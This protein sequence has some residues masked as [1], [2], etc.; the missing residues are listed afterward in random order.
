M[1]KRFFS[2]GLMII[3]AIGAWADVTPT[4]REATNELFRLERQ[5]ANSDYF[6]SGGSLT[7]NN[8]QNKPSNAPDNCWYLAKNNSTTSYI[9]ITLPSGFSL[10]SGDVVDIYGY[11]PLSYNSSRGF[12]LHIETPT[13]DNSKAL[14][15]MPSSGY[16]GYA[17]A[18]AR[19]T[20]TAEDGISGSTTLYIRGDG[21]NAV[22]IQKVSISRS[23]ADDMVP[24]AVSNKTW[25]LYSMA[26]TNDRSGSAYSSSA[27]NDDLFYAKGVIEYKQSTT[28]LR[29]G[30]R[31]T[32]TESNEFDFA[33]QNALGFV[34]ESGT[35]YITVYYAGSAPIVKA[36]TGSASS[37]LSGTEGNADTYYGTPVHYTFTRDSYDTPIFITKGSNNPTITKIIVSSSEYVTA[38]TISQSDNTVTITAGSSNKGNNV[39]TYYTTDG[40]NPTSNSSVYSEAITLTQSCTIKAI[41]ISSESVSSEVASKSC[42]YTSTATALTSENVSVA[43]VTYNGSEQ[44]AVVKYNTT[45]LTKGT[46]YTVTGTDALTNAGSTTFTI[47]GTGNYT[48][49]VSDLTFTITP[50]EVMVTS[51]ITANNKVYD[52]NTTATLV[53]TGATIDGKVGEDELTVSSATGSFSDANVGENKEVTINN[54]TFGGEKAGNYTLSAT[55]NQ[56]TTPATISQ[57][58]NSLSGSIAIEGWTYGATANTPSGVTATFGEVAYKYSIAADGTYG[59]YDAIVNGA[60]GTWWVKAYVDGTENYTAVESDA[61][62]FTIS[63]AQQTAIITAEAT[64]STTYNGQAQP[65]T[66]T[67]DHGALLITYYTNE[68]HTEGATTEAPINAGTYYAIVSQSDANY[69]SDPVNATY[70]IN[71]ATLTATANNQSKTVGEDNPELTVTV[72]GFV[73]EETAEALT[74]AGAYTAPTATCAATTE[75]AAGAY[76]ILPANGAATNYTFNYVKGTLTVNAPTSIYDLYDFATWANENI[77]NADV[78]AVIIDGNLVASEKTMTLNGAISITGGFKVRTNNATTTGIHRAK[79]TGTL[80]INSLKAG[81]WFM[82]ECTS[83]TGTGAVLTFNNNNAYPLDEANLDVNGQVLVSGTIYVVKEDGDLPFVFGDANAQSY[84]HK[85]EI[86]NTDKLPAPVINFDATNK[87]VTITAYNSTKDNTVPTIYFAKNDEDLAVYDGNPISI[88]EPI[89]IKA[90]SVIS[91]SYKSTLVSKAVSGYTISAPSISASE[92]GLVTITPGERSDENEAITTYYT[93]DNSDP[94]TNENKLTYTAPFTP[95]KTAIIRAYS[96]Y[97]NYTTVISDEA[98]PLKVRIGTF[99]PEANVYDF[100][101]ADGDFQEI[102]YASTPETLSYIYNSNNTTASF[103]EISANYLPTATSSAKIMWRDKSGELANGGL[104]AIDGKARYIGITGLTVGQRL[105]IEFNGGSISYVTGTGEGAGKIALGNTDLIA[106][107]S[108]ITSTSTYTVSTAG[109]I[110]IQCGTATVIKNISVLGAVQSYALNVSYDSTKGSVTDDSG[111]ELAESYPEGSTVSL[112]ATATAEGYQFS[113]WMD[114]DDNFLSLK[115]P[116]EVTINSATT[117][118]AVFNQPTSPAPAILSEKSWKF[119]DFTVGTILSGTK[120]Y[121]Y[122]GLYINGHYSDESNQAQILTI[123]PAVNTTIAGELSQRLRIAGKNNSIK[124]TTNVSDFNSDAIAFMAGKPGVVTADVKGSSGNKYNIYIAGELSQVDMTGTLQL[125]QKDITVASSV[126]ISSNNGGHD[127]YAVKFTPETVTAP[128]ISS[129][130]SVGT[131]T[132]GTSN[133]TDE[134]NKAIKTY[135]TIDGTDPTTESTLYDGVIMASGSDITVKAISINTITGTISEITTETGLTLALPAKTVAITAATGGSVTWKVSGTTENTDQ[136]NFSQ[137]T[138]IEVTATPASGYMFQNWTVGEEIVAKTPVYTFTLNNDVTLVAN[139]K[140]MGN[141]VPVILTAGQS[142]TDGRIDATELPETYTGLTNCLWSYANAQ[143]SPAG[144]FNNKVFEIGDFTAYTPT[145]DTGTQWAYDAVVYD[146]I[147]KQLGSNFYVIKQSKGNTGISPAS[148]GCGLFWSANPL[149][150]SRTTSANEG[151]LSLLKALCDHIDASLEKLP[152]GKTADIKFLM[153]HQGEGDGNGSQGPVYYSQ[154]KAVINH[155]RNHLAAKNAKYSNLPFILGGISSS[156]AQ[157]R[158]EVE[159]AKQQLAAED[160]NIYYVSADEVDETGLKS[161]VLHFNA[162]G[163]QSFGNKVWQTIYE[164]NLLLGLEDGTGNSEP[165]ADILE[166]SEPITSTTKWDFSDIDAG[167]AYAEKTDVNGLYLHGSSSNNMTV[168]ATDVTSVTYYDGD[169]VTTS[170]ALRSASGD[171]SK[172]MTNGLTA[173]DVVAVDRMIGVNT[174]AAG[175]FYAVIAPETQPTTDQSARELYLLFNGEKVATINALE[176]WNACDDHTVKLQYTTDKAGTFFLTGQHPYLLYAAKFVKAGE[177]IGGFSI[178]TVAEGGTITLTAPEGKTLNS[179]FDKGEEVTLKATPDDGY[180]FMKWTDENDQKLGSSETLTITM[181]SNVT[182]KA[183]FISS[184]DKPTISK[185]YTVNEDS[186]TYTINYMEGSTLHYTLPGGTE[187]TA[188]DGESVQVNVTKIGDMTAYAMYGELSSETVSQRVYGP[189]PKIESDG[190]YDFSK[191]KEYMAKDYTL[192]SIG[193]GDAVTVGNV[194]LHK[195]DAV[196][197]KTLDRFAFAPKLNSNGK[198]AA[199]WMLL[200]AGRLRA[201]KSVM[202]DTLAILNLETGTYVKITYSGG[203]ALRYMK[204]SSAKLTE[205]TDTLTSDKLYE[206]L[207]DGALL[208]TTPANENSHCDITAISI[209][210]VETVSTPTLALKNDITT[211]VVR[212]RQGASSFGKSVITYYTTDGS[213]PTAENGTAVTKSP[214]DIKLETTST[215]KAIT[216]SEAGTASNVASA[217][218]IVKDESETEA[219]AELATINDDNTATVTGVAISEE[220]TTVTISASVGDAPVTAIAD[221]IF[222]ANNTENVAAI[223]LSETAVTLEG[224]REEILALKNINEA[225][226][227]Y[228]PTTANVTGTNIITKSGTGNEA[229]YKCVDYQLYDGKQSIVPHDFTAET[230]TLNREFTAD[231]RCTVCLPYAFTAT[232]GTYYKFTGINNGKVQMTAQEDGTKLDANTPYIF[233][234]NSGTDAISATDVEVSISDTPQTENAD[235]QFAFIGTYEQIEWDSPE[236]IYGFAAE[237]INGTEIGQFVRVE[238]GA[239][240]DAYRAYLKYTGDTKINDVSATRGMG[241]NIPKKLEIEWLPASTNKNTTT[242]ENVEVPATEDSPVYN[243]NGQRVDDSYKGLIIRNGKVII[244]K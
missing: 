57:A 133:L 13:S 46:D 179:T 194:T 86:R 67:V 28:P 50:K 49:T 111:N 77:N 17:L 128:I 78:D 122:D 172:F 131:I 206:V 96:V 242:I 43:S 143:I 8:I 89:T 218:F 192:G 16:T 209:A 47:E 112:K 117:I 1:T 214:Y 40:S 231:K 26:Q 241:N 53:L 31:M 243:L 94:K 105:I 29:W 19:Y 204:E 62:S 129:N 106:G 150:M 157:Y 197:G 176:A 10:R 95:E 221:N 222:T 60:V 79:G 121:E 98:T 159:T 81:D 59:T 230:A 107:S 130:E 83:S 30:V 153:W 4:T 63:A 220:T 114:A 24:N 34:L 169:V 124:A 126:F 213:V 48:G 102:T 154:L 205:E 76:D 225:T 211:N 156:S 163:A 54:I 125:L 187:Q 165:V 185:T 190:L 75:S 65:L 234:P 45:T 119:D 199:D 64:Q 195:P 232:G 66:A 100:E 139:F 3:L 217:T 178:M 69:T 180:T 141:T 123:S 101:A 27:V 82:V 162:T 223:D 21:S 35:H 11:H 152:S 25:D 91:D 182:I 7:T 44:T 186:Y 56:T 58:T 99:T 189:T 51:G 151:G 142:N 110:V 52:G 228:L 12:N 71:K 144:T 224:K 164:N 127:V 72:E 6:I 14:V 166:E 38:P 90:Q 160:A 138:S 207:S 92:G 55:G 227:V 238:S 23:D 233:V 196:V 219:V 198:N 39:T 191:V 240:I 85:I 116:Y 18:T 88:I 148:G 136:T 84:I 215:V 177:E 216:I 170:K 118:K 37:T 155:V 137:G 175:T 33:S 149:W 158:A 132:E 22:G 9:C 168:K 61:V 74:T 70:T 226:L 32:S 68:G 135:Y 208:L 140:D 120:V 203:A 235:A 236:G 2:L 200:S 184:V 201:K 146:Q 188:S 87:Q 41:S 104:K 5:G 193:Y 36:K 212:L 109:Y 244:R 108:N 183:V 210:N 161:D 73:N 134:A 171:R 202:A 15:N 97:N 147:G 42:E 239:S 174:G 237:E 173:G 93:L 229:T 80:S 167:T 103:Y 115:N 145:S 113:G 181:N 20:I